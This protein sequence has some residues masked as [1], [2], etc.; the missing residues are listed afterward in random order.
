MQRLEF[1]RDQLQVSVK[2]VNS[3]FINSRKQNISKQSPLVIPQVRV[4]YTQTLPRHDVSREVS[5]QI[6][7][8]WKN[9]NTA[10]GKTGPTN[11]ESSTGQPEK[12][13]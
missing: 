6:K 12:E 9:R 5:S 4:E 7:V 2:N 13:Q 3:I 10:E 11:K 1:N 8:V